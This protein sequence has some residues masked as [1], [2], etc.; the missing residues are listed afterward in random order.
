MTWNTLVT[1]K[2][3]FNL[4]EYASSSP[5]V[6]NYEDRGVDQ[7]LTVGT[8]ARQFRNMTGVGVTTQLPPRWS[9][10]ADY[11]YRLLNNGNIERPPDAPPRR[12]S[13]TAGSAPPGAVWT[14]TATGRST[15]SSPP[16][17][18]ST[19]STNGATRRTP[20]SRDSSRPPRT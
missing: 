20:G 2:T 13:A 19:S 9:F 6:D 14:R 8:R 15:A 5:E 10:R 1:Q 12:R 4:F 18:T 7:G 3:S 11:A 16:W 17:R